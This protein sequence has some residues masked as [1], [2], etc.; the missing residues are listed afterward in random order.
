[1][2]E[3]FVRGLELVE[4]EPDEAARIG[5]RYIGVEARL[6]RKALDRNAPDPDTLR[7]REAIGALLSQMIEAGYLDRVPSGGTDLSFLDG[8]RAER[9]RQGGLAP[10]AE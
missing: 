10:A 3:G 4:R 8:V 7:N 6:V 9:I 5:S 2:V 1:V